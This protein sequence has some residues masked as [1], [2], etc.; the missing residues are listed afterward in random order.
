[1]VEPS[2]AS[3]D[4]SAD[5]LELL[6]RHRAGDSDALGR[7][8]ERYLPRIT[9]IVRVRLG[10]FLRNRESIDDVVQNV[11]IRLVQAIDTYE[12]RTDAHWIDWVAKLAHNEVL[13]LVRRERAQKRDNGRARGCAE[14]EVQPSAEFVAD[15][16]SV[17]TRAA[18]REMEEF[19]GLGTDR[20]GSCA[21][22][23]RGMPGTPPT[24]QTG[25]W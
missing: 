15:Q 23:R 25:T 22:Q 20:R 18:R 6:R 5:S 9:R 10:T 21:A 7:L 1:M 11:L 13:N 17:I 19:V 16:S 12:E 4:A 14:R 2:H 3:G 24:R 8:I